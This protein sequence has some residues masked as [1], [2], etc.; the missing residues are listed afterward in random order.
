MTVPADRRIRE[1][2]LEAPMADRAIEV[3]PFEGIYRLTGNA[4]NGNLHAW[5]MFTNKRLPENWTL[6]GHRKKDED[7]VVV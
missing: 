1:G 2:G 7:R 3:P 4:F 6:E 5:R